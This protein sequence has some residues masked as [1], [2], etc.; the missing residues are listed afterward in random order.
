MLPGV[1]KPFTSYAQAKRSPRPRGC[2]HVSLLTYHCHCCFH[3]RLHS[4]ALPQ[5][6]KVN[7]GPS[8]HFP[9]SRTQAK[10]DR[11]SVGAAGMCSSGG[12]AGGGLPAGF[13]RQPAPPPPLRG[14]LS[15]I[16]ETGARLH[17]VRP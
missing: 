14:S 1:H 4:S 6:L 9:C 15:S 17:L 8:H 10:G 13:K 11:W 3:N 12:P 16:T 7:S 2:S 5:Q